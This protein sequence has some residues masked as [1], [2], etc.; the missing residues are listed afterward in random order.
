MSEARGSGLCRQAG[1][2][3]KLTIL[4]DGED[5]G[6]GPSCDQ[7]RG[8]QWLSFASRIWQPGPMAATISN[9]RSLLV[10]DRGVPCQPESSPIIH[11]NQS[12]GL[13]QPPP[14]LVVGVSRLMGMRR[15]SPHL[16]LSFASGV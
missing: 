3:L 12:M 10:F 8:G 14:P 9:Y 1:I 11:I 4:Q 2:M 6:E 5:V 13:V 16:H 7:C 15:A